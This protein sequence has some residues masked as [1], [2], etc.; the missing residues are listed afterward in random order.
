MAQQFVTDHMVCTLD[1]CHNTGLDSAPDVG[2]RNSVVYQKF[3]VSMHSIEGNLIISL[4]CVMRFYVF[5]KN[6]IFTKK[7]Q[8]RDHINIIQFV[9]KLG[10]RTGGIFS[11]QLNSNLFVQY[12]DTMFNILMSINHSLETDQWVL[13]RMEQFSSLTRP[14]PH[15]L[16]V[17]RYHTGRFNKLYS[18][19]Y[20]HVIEYQNRIICPL[21]TVIINVCWRYIGET[22]TLMAGNITSIHSV[23]VQQDG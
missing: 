4:K 9:V 2:L 12:C 10:Y 16:L 23:L 11:Y 18:L 8:L 3:W 21:I 20:E 15:L 6:V 19:K 5:T 22:H 17:E 7:G 1:H 13:E 14:N